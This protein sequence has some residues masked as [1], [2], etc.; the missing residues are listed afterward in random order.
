MN[1]V[2]EALDDKGVDVAVVFP[3][4]NKTFSVGKAIGAS[5]IKVPK[6]ADADVFKESGCFEEH[7]LL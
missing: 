4:A 6:S 2:A 7:H 1:A 5:I 3:T